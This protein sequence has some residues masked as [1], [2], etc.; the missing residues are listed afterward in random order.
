MK[1]YTG[2][3]SEVRQVSAGASH[4]AVVTDEGYVYTWGFGLGGKLGLG[5]TERE[6]VK[7]PENHYFPTPMLVSAIESTIV[8]QVR[9]CFVFVFVLFFTWIS[10]LLS[11]EFFFVFFYNDFKGIELD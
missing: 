5:T 9:D 11:N 8:R 1:F 10:F 7:P 6:G 3:P 2:L 4:T